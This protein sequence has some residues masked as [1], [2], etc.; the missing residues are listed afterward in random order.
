LAKTL[1][2]GRTGLRLIGRLTGDSLMGFV[3]DGRKA[4]SIEY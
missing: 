1:K 2:P 3:Q 4:V